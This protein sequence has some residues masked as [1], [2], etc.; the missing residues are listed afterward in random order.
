M[1]SEMCIR[2]RNRSANQTSL[3]SLAEQNV[4]LTVGASPFVQFS[5]PYN[6]QSQNMN[7]LAENVVS[8]VKSGLLRAATGLIWGNS[9]RRQEETPENAEEQLR[10]VDYEQKLTMTQAFK[11]PLKTGLVVEK[12]PN[13]LYFA[14]V[15]NQN[16]VMVFDAMLGEKKAVFPD[17]RSEK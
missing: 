13:N 8:T 3:S 16:R 12:A 15:D 1:G 4:V 6:Y 17:V 7:E 14:V 2:D 11:D 9:S 10:R 5:A